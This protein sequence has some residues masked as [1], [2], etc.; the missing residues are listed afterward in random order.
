L[1][2]G[3]AIVTGATRGIGRAICEALLADGRDVAAV[4][5]DEVMLAATVAGRSVAPGAAIRGF[6]CEMSCDEV[7]SACLAQVLGWRGDLG[8]AG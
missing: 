1:T 3:A 5:C 8:G 7:V 6:S 2:R 4:D